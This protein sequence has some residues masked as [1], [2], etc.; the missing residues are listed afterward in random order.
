M[1]NM[2]DSTIHIKTLLSI[3]NIYNPTQKFYAI[4]A[5]RFEYKWMS[6][7]VA[8]AMVDSYFNFVK[9]LQDI[10]KEPVSWLQEDDNA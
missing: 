4:K 6:N 9:D 7:K 10:Q 1:K 8:E 2:T 3:M 5:I